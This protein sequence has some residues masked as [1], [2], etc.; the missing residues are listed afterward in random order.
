MTVQNPYQGRMSER[1]WA[2]GYASGREGMSRAANPYG[3]AAGFA[4]AWEDGWRAGMDAR[5]AEGE[6][7]PVR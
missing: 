2:R 3:L 6:W 4:R 7:R 1:A 5:R